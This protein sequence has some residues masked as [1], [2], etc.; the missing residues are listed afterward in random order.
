MILNG[1]GISYT[2]PDIGAEFVPPLPEHPR[3]KIVALCKHLT[4]RTLGKGNLLPY[5]YW[6]FESVTTDEMADVLLKLKVRRP[7]MF[8]EAQRATGLAALA[9]KV[10]GA[11]PIVSDPVE[12]RLEEVRSLGVEHTINPAK[13]DLV[14]KVREYCGGRL[15]E[16]VMEAS[17]S[18]AAIRSAFDAVCN[19]GRI[20]LTGWPKNDTSIATGTITKKELDVRGARTSAGEFEEALDLIASG[21]GS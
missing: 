14:E 7:Y 10:Y 21:I 15:A 5:E 1:P 11:T 17:G 2:E 12:E 16:V 6:A 18:N 4:N 8:E 3:E 19:A 13:E 20:I 9:A